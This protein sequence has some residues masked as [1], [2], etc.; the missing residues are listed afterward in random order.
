MGVSRDCG[1]F[2][3]A[4]NISGGI[5]NPRH[6]IV[7]QDKKFRDRAAKALIKIKEKHEKAIL[8]EWCEAIGWDE[9]KAAAAVEH[10]QADRDK[11]LERDRKGREQKRKRRVAA[12]V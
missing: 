2:F 5:H 11:L 10:A 4:L 3:V 6:A 8:A 9:E 7:R 12:R 1:H